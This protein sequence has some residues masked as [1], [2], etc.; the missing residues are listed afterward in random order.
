VLADLR[1]GHARNA[2][3]LDAER[4][5]WHG[6]RVGETLCQGLELSHD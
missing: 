1:G 2:R 3:I 5:I 4:L 6:L